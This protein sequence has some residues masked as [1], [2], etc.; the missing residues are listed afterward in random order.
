MGSSSSAGIR[1]HPRATCSRHAGRNTRRLVVS[2]G[3]F[4]AQPTHQLWDYE[5]SCVRQL[6]LEEL[7]LL[8][9]LSFGHRNQRS[10]LIVLYTADSPACQAFEQEVE[11][12]ASGLRHERAFVAAALDVSQ[13]KA[14]TFA[15]NML[16]VSHVPA[17]L[18]YPEAARGCLKFLGPDMSAP[19]MLA[20]INK[21]R[22]TALP[23]TAASPGAA[24]W[25]LQEAAVPLAVTAVRAAA[26]SG[27]R[28]AVV[29]SLQQQLAPMKPTPLSAPQAGGYWTQGRAAFWGGLLLCSLLL[30]AWDL[31][32]ADAWEDWCLARRQAAR[33][34]GKKFSAQENLDDMVSLMMNGLQQRVTGMTA[35][36]AG[37]DS[38]G[39]AAQQQQQQ[40]QQ[41]QEQQQEQ[42][43][44]Q[45][46]AA[47]QG[48][49]ADEPSN[50]QPQTPLQQQQGQ[51][52][53]M[54]QQRTGSWVLDQT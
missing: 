44:G 38:G 17:V 24:D 53:T 16:G 50:G 52:L 33:A 13:Q 31:K 42:Q 29:A 1:T 9:R 5:G 35:A 21:A 30:L 39:V 41:Q 25:Q 6:S 47:A 51:D 54:K 43:Q 4:G 37:D 48:V 11:R 19:G 46:I 3:W 2:S 18:L 12:L 36:A 14:A 49:P 27:D 10:Y 32:L 15:S 34:R 40:Q 20:A 8:H 22:R 28:E 45:T 26:L 23:A 7:Q